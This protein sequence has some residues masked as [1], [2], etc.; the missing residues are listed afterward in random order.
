MTYPIPDAALDDRLGFVGTAGS[1]KTFNAGSG[2]ERVLAAAGRVVIPDPLGVWYGLALG[3]DG[4]T[5]PPWRAAKKLVIFGGEHGD[6]PLGEQH[7]A[8]IGETVAGMAESAVLDLSGLGTKAAERRFMLAFLT[9]LYRHATGDPLHLVFDEA[10][11]WAPQ[12]LWAAGRGRDEGEPAKLLGMMETVVRRGRIKGFIPWLITQRPAV[13]SKDVLSQVDGLIAFK[14]TATQDRDALDDWIEG[15]ADRAQGKAIK[16]SLPTLPVGTGVVWLPS[17]GILETAAFPPKLT[18]DSSRTPKR[19]EKRQRRDLK[20]L[21]LGALKEKLA[22]VVEEAKA[23]DPKLLKAEIAE[24]R[25]KL[26]VAERAG[27]RNPKS[28]P[29][30]QQRP[31]WPDQR[32]EVTK[33]RRDVEVALYRAADAMELLADRDRRLAEISDLC[34]KA[35]HIPAGQGG[36]DSAPPRRESSRKPDQPTPQPPR[37]SRPVRLSR[38]GGESGLNAAA[39]GIAGL[40][41]GMP[42]YQA[43]WAD[44]LILGGFRPGS[45][46]IRKSQNQLVEEAYIDGSNDCVVATERLIESDILAL[47]TPAPAEV[48][49]TWRNK[50]RGP[51]GQMATWLA[52]N[53]PATREEIAAGIGMSATA[54]WSRKGFK[55]LLGS[56]LATQGADGRLVPHPLLVDNP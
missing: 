10:D 28:D 7:G 20:P 35:P 47:T 44:L 3:A 19:G 39:E 55:D 46:W 40:L 34:L 50:L 27:Q 24:L 29:E 11:M 25:R 12:K 22:T 30:S 13:L 23:N 51:G 15:Q 33:L 5:E 9:A 56:N 42:G 43:P 49:A 31:A 17:R 21:D 18:F 8:L 52:E 53:G 6:L 54:G 16:D 2:V 26:A 4:K 41:K 1:G 48:R 14:L 45:G 37:A 36:G 32:E 38:V